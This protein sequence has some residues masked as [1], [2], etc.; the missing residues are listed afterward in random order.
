MTNRVLRQGKNVVLLL[1]TI[2]CL[3]CPFAPG[4]AGD[5]RDVVP[6]SRVKLPRDLSFRKDYRVQWWYFTGHLFDDAGREFG[7]ELTFFAVNI[8]KTPFRSA[9]GVNTLYLSHFA[10]SDVQEKRFHTA[11]NSDVGAYRYA[12]A[13][14]NRLRVWIGRNI[15]TGSGE[16]MHIKAV[17]EKAGMALDLDLL[18][19][20][21]VVL[22]GDRGY[23]RK[24][25][26]SPLIASLYFSFTDLKTAGTLCL[27]GKTSTVTGR[28]WFDREISSQGLNENAAGWDWFSLKLDDGRDI[29]L[30]R[31]RKK[32]GSIDPFS[33]GTVVERDGR[34]RHLAQPEFTVT[35]LDQY[36]S[37]KTGARYPARWEIAVPSERLRLLVTPLIQDQEFVAASSTWNHYWEGTCAIEGTVPGRAY[38][39]LTGY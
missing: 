17:D 36:T 18:P 7:Y 4:W 38:V 19:Q 16:R 35:A 6:G 34:S 25:E 23:S 14:E 30:Y 28:S 21:P 8:Q 5:Y 26:V 37:E 31:M 10:V 11:E 39:E 22:Q 29:M 9:F 15:L 2:W 27:G 33:S 1:C 20:K 32:D 24:S 13:A 12:G 3:L